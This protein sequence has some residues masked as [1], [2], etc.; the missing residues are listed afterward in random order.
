MAEEK[1]VT[2]EEL[3]ALMF[4]SLKSS[5]LDS[6]SWADVARI[7]LGSIQDRERDAAKK[8]QARRGG[9]KTG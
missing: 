4:K 9:P 3:E 2:R 8:S 5:T 7:L 6:P 1:E